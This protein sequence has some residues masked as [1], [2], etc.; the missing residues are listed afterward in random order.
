MISIIILAYNEAACI[1]A[2]ISELK[3]QHFLGEY[4][5][6]LADGGSIDA[7]VALARRQ[8][9]RIVNARKGKALQMNDAVKIANGAVLFFVH[10]D[11]EFPKNTLETI[12]KNIDAGFDAGGFANVFKNHNDKIKSLGNWVNF[13]F[14]DRREQS[15]KGLFYGDNGIF[16]RTT[17][18]NAL[19]GFKEVPIMEDYDFSVRLKEMGYTTVKIKEISIVVSERRHVKAGF[20]KTR[21]QW[22]M[23]RKLYNWGVSPELLAKWYGDV[24]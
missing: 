11:M 21:F 3:N 4:E 14:L 10:A 24:R 18:F 8:G 12:Q 23:I 9:V 16:V 6:I 7:T 20:F 22:V 13:R 2:V 19:G 5:I 15:D 17:V 1:Q